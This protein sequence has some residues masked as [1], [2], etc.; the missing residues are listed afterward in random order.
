[1]GKQLIPSPGGKYPGTKKTLKFISDA[2]RDL[3][4]ALGTIAGY[5]VILSGV[6][7]YTNTQFPGIQFY[8]SGF[9]SVDGEVVVFRGGQKYDHVE[10]VNEY[11]QEPYLTSGGLVNQNAYFEKYA[12]CVPAPTGNSFPFTE[13]K[14]LKT[15][16][17]F[18]EA[19]LVIDANY[20]HTD[21]NFT[22]L[23][24]EKLQ[25]IAPGAEV[26]VQSDWDVENA[27]SD[28]YI[29]NKPQIFKRFGKHTFTWPSGIDELTVP[30]Y[31]PNL[32]DLGG[33]YFL[34][35]ELSY[36]L[37]TGVAPDYH[38]KYRK[39]LTNFEVTIKRIGGT[40]ENSGFKLITHIFYY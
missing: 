4:N 31:Y 15:L 3:H 29:K 1:M 26:N 37:G 8:D 21:N 24:K 28:A 9:L 16:R 23:L 33:N 39:M 2:I 7:M 35:P 27:D 12:R 18:T 32:D 5:R 38:V 11:Q 17:Y 22:T 34:M 13:L 36:G 19:A 10:I 30:C 25:A 6:N 20:I 14:R 40:S